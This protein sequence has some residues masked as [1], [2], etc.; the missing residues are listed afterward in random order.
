MATK[1]GSDHLFRLI[2]S[3]S[4]GE[5]G[6]FKKFAGRHGH[7]ENNYI[8][9]FNRILA[10]PAFEEATLRKEFKRLDMMKV[11]LWDM[12]MQSL[13]TYKKDWGVE[14][15]LLRQYAYIH[16]LRG[17]GLLNKALKTLDKAL[18]TAKDFDIFWVQQLLIR[19]R[20][21]IILLSFKDHAKRIDA[22]QHAFGELTRLRQLEANR[23]KF[24]HALHISKALQYQSNFLGTTTSHP[25]DL[26]D[27]RLME[28]DGEQQNPANE[29]LRL[30]AL[31]E[32]YEVKREAEQQ[33][34]A[35]LSLYEFE[36]KLIHKKQPLAQMKALNNALT[37]LINACLNTNRLAKA[38]A[39]LPKVLQ[40]VTAG[41]EKEAELTH[42]YFWLQSS[43]YI[44]FK[45]G[46]HRQGIRL[47]NEH[48]QRAIGMNAENNYS[49]FLS[50]IYQLKIVLELSMR[51]FRDAMISV[52][53]ME[54]LNKKDSS[55]RLY[56]DCE[57][58]KALVQLD[59]KNEQ[60]MTAIVTSLLKKARKLGLS[61]GERKLLLA[62][63][64]ING[65][66][67]QNGLLQTRAEVT[68]LKEPVELFQLLNV[69]D[70]L[71]SRISGKEISDILRES[72]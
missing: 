31:A 51:S 26:L 11:Y 48:M 61:K 13:V 69:S 55:P 25:D 23:D 52:H 21:S 63:K 40:A 47:L 3:L 43:L 19:E 10:Q 70:W 53:N 17:K 46:K 37:G 9:L 39:L 1:K 34:H 71:E 64:R 68:K 22:T 49:V 66:N 54:A 38:E 42:Y 60:Q 32:Y 59:L 8:L 29:R 41:N 65:A 58:I 20:R 28:K 62:L 27:I 57:I 30:Y 24:L 33:F 45:K 5:R 36:Q 44:H 35:F 12:I 4:S 18:K 14:Y 56:K 15:E 7:E 16:I 72:L 50:N 67:F 6:Y 2:H